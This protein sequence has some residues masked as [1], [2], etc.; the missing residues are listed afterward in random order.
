MAREGRG[1]SSP[2]RA[3]HRPGWR[4]S[5][6]SYLWPVPPTS[7]AR[8]P[9]TGLPGVNSGRDGRLR[10]GAPR[11]ITAA[12]VGG[13]AGGSAFRLHLLGFGTADSCASLPR[14]SRSG[15]TCGRTATL[16]DP[17]RRSI[18]PDRWRSWFGAAG[19]WTARG[20]H[21]AAPRRA[22]G[23][24]CPTPASTCQA[25]L[26]CLAP[27]GAGSRATP[28]RPTA[29]RTTPPPAV[30]NSAALLASRPGGGALPAAAQT[31]TAGPWRRWSD[32]VGW[33]TLSGR[34]PPFRATRWV[35]DLGQPPPFR[36]TR[37]VEDLGQPAKPR[38]LRYLGPPKIKSGATRRRLDLKF[39]ADGGAQ[40]LLLGA[41]EPSC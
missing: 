14:P 5:S 16:R 6:G 38:W 24:F 26:S 32:V 30:G 35:E 41:F 34:P 9:G 39:P 7:K 31:S 3:G 1:G 36:A 2:P 13:N 12:P 17:F 10:P 22:G 19:L 23:D 15:S 8:V 33:S 11:K 27:D 21:L 4:R 40:R 18:L 29:G 25:S 20:L 28:P 37:W